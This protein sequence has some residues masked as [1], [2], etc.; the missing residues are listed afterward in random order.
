MVLGL[1]GLKDFL[2]TVPKASFA[3]S[4]EGPFYNSPS[5]GAFSAIWLSHLL[6]KFRNVREQFFDAERFGDIRI[7]AR[8]AR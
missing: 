1:S 4:R 8:S 7:R 2:A 3:Q 5:T 6:V